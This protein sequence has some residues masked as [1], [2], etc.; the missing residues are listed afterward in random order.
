MRIV[1]SLLVGVAIGYFAFAP[2]M[3]S[4]RQELLSKIK[5]MT[6]TGTSSSK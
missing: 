1:V 6:A 3:A 4:N 2:E 5:E